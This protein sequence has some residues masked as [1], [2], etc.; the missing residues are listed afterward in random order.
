MQAIAELQVQ[1]EPVRR[2]D[3]TGP[4]SHETGLTAQTTTDTNSDM[5]DDSSL[6]P[7]IMTGGFL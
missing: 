6:K 1:D 2:I 4:I 3:A 7:K 5:K